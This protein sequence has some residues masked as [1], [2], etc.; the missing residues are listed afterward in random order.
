MQLCCAA[1]H[2][3]H[4]SGACPASRATIAVPTATVSA[5]A[6]HGCPARWH[7]VSVARQTAPLLW[8]PCSQAVLPTASML[9]LAT[10]RL[11]A[12][13]SLFVALW[14][15]TTCRACQ[16]TAAGT[17][18][19]RRAACATLPS[20]TD[21]HVSL[22]LS[23]GF[24]V[25][26]TAAADS[27]LFGMPQAGTAVRSVAG[28]ARGCGREV[29]VKKLRAER[30]VRLSRLS[31]K[32]WH[33][34]GHCTDG[35]IADAGA[36]QDAGG[37]RGNQ[38][39]VPSA[40]LTM[41]GRFLPCPGPPPCSPARPRS[42]P[43]GD[44]VPAAAEA[45]ARAARSG[46]RQAQAAA[47]RAGRAL[48]RGRHAGVGGAAAA[49]HARGPAA[50]NCQARRVTRFRILQ[51]R[52]IDEKAELLAS[53]ARGPPPLFACTPSPRPAALHAMPRLVHCL[54]YAVRP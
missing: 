22:L 8:Q 45:P 15:V 3:N 44:L 39:F 26:H 5:F 49:G 24:L 18:A 7:A 11:A 33:T 41:A 46:A 6:L 37:L 30:D 40:L 25:R 28:A 19:A 52:G 53:S 36:R 9:A 23:C 16:G 42:R 1:W 35:H 27:Y 12:S 29:R 51:L 38:V 43:A 32:E 10:A 14:P 31:S 48:A 17:P 54:M 20:V 21:A 4:R 50:A 47:Q 34:G 2:S 13:L